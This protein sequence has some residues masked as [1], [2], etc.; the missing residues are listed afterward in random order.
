MVKKNHKC[1]SQDFKFYLGKF[2]NKIPIWYNAYY[3]SVFT[4]FNNTKN[5]ENLTLHHMGIFLVVNLLV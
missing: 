5:K 4:A 2:N 1:Y 3:V